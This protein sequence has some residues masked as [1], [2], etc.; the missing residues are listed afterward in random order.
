MSYRCKALCW[1]ASYH[2]HTW[3][4]CTPFVPKY[5][6]IFVKDCRAS[7]TPQFMSETVNA[8]MAWISFSCQWIIKSNLALMVAVV[9]LQWLPSTAAVTLKKPYSVLFKCRAIHHRAA[10]DW[11]GDTVVTVS[12]FPSLCFSLNHHFCL[13]LALNLSQVSTLSIFCPL[14]LFLMLTG[15]ITLHWC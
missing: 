6:R 8:P 5:N 14:F 11:F 2:R 15:I 10:G 1:T 3:Q 12:I 13:S 4:L 7:V 9:V